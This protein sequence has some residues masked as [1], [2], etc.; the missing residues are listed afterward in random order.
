M[1]EVTQDITTGVIPLRD[2]QRIHENNPCIGGESS[3]GSSAS[4]HVVLATN[5]HTYRREKVGKD[6]LE[7]QKM[8]SVKENNQ[9]ECT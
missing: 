7:V 3:L 1:Y 4:F 8:N 6:F 5:L 2:P 9:A